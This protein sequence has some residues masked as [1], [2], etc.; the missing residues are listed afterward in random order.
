MFNRFLISIFK[1]TK[2]VAVVFFYF[3][4][5]SVAPCQVLVTA[6]SSTSLYV[7][8]T[9]V[10]QEHQHG[11]IHLHKIYI[12]LVTQPN[13][14][15]NSYCAFN[16]VEYNISDLRVYTLYV[17]RVSAVN[18]AGEGPKSRAVTARTLEGG[19]FIH[20]SRKEIYICRSISYLVIP[21]FIVS[22]S[23]VPSA[24]PMNLSLVRSDSLSIV[25]EW[26]PVPMEYENGIIKGYRL[27][28]RVKNSENFMS[29]ADD[30]IYSENIAVL[31]GLEFNTLYSIR[32]AAY[33]R[34]GS[35]NFSQ[36][37]EV[38]TKTCK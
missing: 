21:M 31:S 28:Y 37:I 8:W 11:K 25:V 29:M 27:V 26:R 32:V 6:Q 12:S 17:I 35:G 10:P 14:Y 24:P 15:I 20:I 33:T 2:S 19:K 4:V 9:A 36:P 22:I 38:R 18:E 23:V 30:S 7:S 1:G 13:S 34:V 3:P 5:P 16:P